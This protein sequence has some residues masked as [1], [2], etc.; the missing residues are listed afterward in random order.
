MLIV[1]M[2][3]YIVTANAK[4]K[5]FKINP[6]YTLLKQNQYKKIIPISFLK[7]IPLNSYSQLEYH[8]AIAGPVLE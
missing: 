6:V 8:H 7:T 1:D 5:N 2:G 4:E 3:Y